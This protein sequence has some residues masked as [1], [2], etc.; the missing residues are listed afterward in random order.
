MQ[1]HGQREIVRAGVTR[2]PRT[3]RAKALLPLPQRTKARPRRSTASMLPNNPRA[4]PALPARTTSVFSGRAPARSR[5][6]ESILRAPRP[7]AMSKRSA[8]APN[9]RAASWNLPVRASVRARPSLA[10][11]PTVRMTVAPLRPGRS[12]MSSAREVPRTNPPL[13]PP[14]SILSALLVLTLPAAVTWIAVTHD[15]NPPLA[16]GSIVLEKSSSENAAA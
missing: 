10:P 1:P 12:M 2:R 16:D 13:R 6:S 8:P 14:P 4:A 9:G 3:T 7:L 11:G 5:T 15:V